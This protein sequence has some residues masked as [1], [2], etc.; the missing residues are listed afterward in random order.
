MV[1]FEEFDVEMKVL[2]SSYEEATIRRFLNFL[3]LGK[4]DSTSHGVVYTRVNHGLS[5]Y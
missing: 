4:C 1:L 5:G 2:R 3:D